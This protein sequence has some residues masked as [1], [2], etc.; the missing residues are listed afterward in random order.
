[1]TYKRDPKVTFTEMCIYIDKNIYKENFDADKCYQ[2]M[3]HIFYTLAVKNRYFKKESDYD[4]FALYA[5]TRLFLRYQKRNLNVIKSVLNYVNTIIYP[6]KVDYQSQAFNQVFN[7]VDDE[8]TTQHL[9]ESLHNKAA[10]QNDNLMRVEFEYYLKKI[11]NTVKEFLHRSPYENNKS[12]IHNIYIS[13]LLS[14]LNSV[15]MSNQNIKRVRNKISR[16]LPVGTLLDSIYKEERKD[17]IILYNLDKSMY[18]YISTVTKQLFKLIQ[19]DLRYIIGSYEFS[20]SVIQSILFS[21]LEIENTSC[22]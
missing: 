9:Q 5:A 17:Y 3:Y 20:E 22:D 10:S 8:E 1:M 7:P 12:I 4:E 2:Y 16:R 19:K 18:N 6:A 13:C 15:T 21:P 14:I 11:P